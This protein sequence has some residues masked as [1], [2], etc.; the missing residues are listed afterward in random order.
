MRLLVVEDNDSVAELLRQ[1]LTKAGF[2]SDLA[3]TAEDAQGLLTASRYAAVILDLGLPDADGLD[4]LRWMRS[5]RDATPVLALT[6]RGGVNDR[7]AGLQNGADDY[8]VKPFAVEELT[9]RLQ[10][11]LR[12]PGALLGRRLQ[13]GNLTFDSET[14]EA[15]VDD[16]PQRLSVRELEILELLMR[17]SG[18]VATKKHLEDQLFGAAGDVGSNAIEVYVHRLR[19]SLDL[20][21][22]TANIHTVRGVGYILGATA[23]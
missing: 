15:F 19:K 9:A 3:A 2:A 4:V 10:A 23:P 8:L 13:V 18:R 22:S 6:A 1:A 21:G 14:R 17:R 16:R 7:V 20:M 5:R 11:L 12:R